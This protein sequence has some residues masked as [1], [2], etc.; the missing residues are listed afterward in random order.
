[1]E[2]R[3][4]TQPLKRQLAHEKLGG[5]L[6]AADLAERDRARAVAV[7]L[8]HATVGR[9]GLAR[10]LGGKRLPGRLASGGLARGLLGAGHSVGLCLH[11]GR[12]VSTIRDPFAPPPYP[13]VVKM[14]QNYQD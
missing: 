9:G 8:L 13:S 5:L 10:G 14:A 2:A 1:M 6:V 12:H 4:R 7:G 11:I 3:G